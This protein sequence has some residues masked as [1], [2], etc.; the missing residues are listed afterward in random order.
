MQHRDTSTFNTDFR[1]STLLLQVM[2]TCAEALQ[3]LGGTDNPSRAAQLYRRRLQDEDDAEE[4]DR[5]T[6]CIANCQYDSA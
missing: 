6:A 4:V 2:E 3:G 5:R 1:M